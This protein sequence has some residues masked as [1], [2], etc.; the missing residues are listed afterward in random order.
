MFQCIHIIIIYIFGL[1]GTREMRTEF[2]NVNKS[3]MTNFVK[4]ISTYHRFRGIKKSRVYIIVKKNSVP[5]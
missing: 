4:R 3:M 1:V 5:E 2:V